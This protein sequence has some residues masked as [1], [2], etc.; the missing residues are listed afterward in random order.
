L[1]NDEMDDFTTQPGVPNALF[2][3][4]QSESNAIAPGHRPLSSMTADDFVA[5]RELSF[6]TGSPGGPTIISSVL[7]TV[8]NWMRLEWTRRRRSM[9][10]GFITSGCRTGYFSSSSFRPPWSKG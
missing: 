5:R 6:V 1:L 3:L 4:I 9:R 8:I 7:L 10:R 2:G